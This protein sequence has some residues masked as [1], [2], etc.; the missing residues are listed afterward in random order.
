MLFYLR[1]LAPHRRVRLQVN[2]FP[3]PSLATSPTYDLP[4]L[5]QSLAE[6]G[7]E[8]FFARTTLQFELDADR[9]VS[10]LDVFVY[11]YFLYH[12]DWA[13]LGHAERAENER[14]GAVDD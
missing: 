3:P 1:P 2:Q 4:H 11:S 8:L 5:N 12:L 6:G 7:L 10:C 9:G 13:T 14:R